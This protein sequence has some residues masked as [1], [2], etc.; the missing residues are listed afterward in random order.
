MSILSKIKSW[1]TALE[2]YYAGLLYLEDNFPLYWL[3]KKVLSKVELA[4][5]HVLALKKLSTDGIVI[6]ALKDKSQLNSLIIRELA[7]R[8]GLPRPVYC[9][10][11]NM[12]FWQPF[13]M[14]VRVIVSYLYH[15]LF[16]RDVP[17]DARK[18]EFMGRIVKDGRSVIIHLG[19]SEWIDNP[20]TLE[21]ITELI[22]A[23]KN[24]N[25][26]IYIVPLMITYGRRREK[27]NESLFNILTQ[28]IS[29]VERCQ[30]YRINTDL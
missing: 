27:Q 10:G 8:K 14:A 22:R 6:Y 25:E 17:L 1:T 2:D 3:V 9:H 5:E 23:Q 7:A 28:L 20:F 19:G 16:D 11:I 30:L 12:I 13:P 29:C 4:D 15:R 21:T 24:M 18:R 26:P